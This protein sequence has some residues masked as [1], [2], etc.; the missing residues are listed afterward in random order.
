MTGSTDK[1]AA[2]RLLRGLENGGIDPSDAQDIAAGLDP[3]LVYF[4][5]HFL[6]E[7]YPASE[8]AATA[9]LDR[10]LTLTSGHSAIIAS[11]KAG[12]QDSVTAWFGIEYTFGEF[13]GRGRELIEMIVEKLES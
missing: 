7:T 8:P 6:R 12:E 10:V 4:I 9:V 11:F 3:V 13:R 1:A 2:L 5:V